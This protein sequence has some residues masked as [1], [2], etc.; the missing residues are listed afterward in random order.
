F[1]DLG[2]IVIDEAHETTFK[3]FDPAPRYNARD[4]AV[5]LSKQFNSAL[6]LGSATP[7]LESYFTA[8]HQKY[9]LIELKKRFGRVVPPKIDL[10][11]IKDKHKRKKMTGHFSDELIAAISE[12][13][14][15][16][17]QVILFQNRRG[18]SP[19][20]ECQTCGHSPQ[21]PNCDVSLTYHRHNNSLR[22]HYSGYHMAMQ[23][24]CLTFDRTDLTTKEYGTEQIETELNAL[25]PK[26]YIGSMDL[27][28]SRGNHGY[29]KI[30]TAFEQKTIDILV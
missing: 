6:L 4:A 14:D 8:Q 22:C 12:T 11:D 19:I 21:C 17:K 16:A 3:Q 2:L 18:Y 7:S 1:Q 26:P 29:E 20:L 30:I 24:R 25:F 23:N 27:D 13:L 15:Q 28:T 9:K 5:V 10:V